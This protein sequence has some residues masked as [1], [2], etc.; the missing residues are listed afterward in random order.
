MGIFPHSINKIKLIILILTTILGI[1]WFY[2]KIPFLCPI[3]L[4]TG[5][6]CAMCGS[7]RAI[8]LL[9]EFNIIDS[10]KMNPLAIMWLYFLILGYIKL[11]FESFNIIIFKNT[12]AIR[13]S[14]LRYILLSAS[15]INMIYLNLF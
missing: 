1:L 8:Q 5:M 6:Y 9:L 7:T 14:C 4:Y 3:K 11:F 13:N 10:L 15:F 12:F 2:N